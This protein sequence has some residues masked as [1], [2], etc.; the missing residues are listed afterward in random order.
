MSVIT[1]IMAV[2]TTSAIWEYDPM[3]SGNC[4]LGNSLDVVTAVRTLAFKVFSI[5][6]YG[7]IGLIFI[8]DSMF[9]SMH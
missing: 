6:L 3:L 1:K 8:V 7:L 4:V 9:G 5:T 2:E